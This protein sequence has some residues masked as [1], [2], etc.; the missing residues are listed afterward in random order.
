MS[1]PQSDNRKPILLTIGFSHKS[2]AECDVWN[3]RLKPEYLDNLRVAYYEVADLEGAPSFVLGMI[4]RGMRKKI[5]EAEQAHFVPLLSGGEAWKKLV[6]YSAPDDAYVVVA[7]AKGRSVW[8][9]HGILTD[10]KYAQL[11][12]ALEKL[13]LNPQ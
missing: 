2:S 13:I 1:F 5:P 11:H 6:G 9:T 10:A 7:D 4:L 3:R 12:A 8:L